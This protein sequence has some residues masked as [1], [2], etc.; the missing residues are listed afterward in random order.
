MSVHQRNGLSPS[1]SFSI[2]QNMFRAMAGLMAV[3]SFLSAWINNSASTSIM[4]PVALA[5]TDELE[6][7]SQNYQ[8]KKDIIKQASAAVNG[9][10]IVDR[11]R[12]SVPFMLLI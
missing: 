4:L 10:R 5:I 2:N 7:H 12:I 1:I 11:K 3:T 8:A 6:S 9:E